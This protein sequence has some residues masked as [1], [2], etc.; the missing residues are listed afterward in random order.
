V[1]SCRSRS[2]LRWRGNLVRKGPRQ[3]GALPCF[4]REAADYFGSERFDGSAFRKQKAGGANR[5]SGFTARARRSGASTQR[6]PAGPP[7]I[8]AERPAYRRHRALLQ[9]GSRSAPIAE[10]TG[11]DVFVTTT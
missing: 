3:G 4:Q 2:R 7:V 10:A 8:A 1:S 9:R 6:A 5:G 11:R